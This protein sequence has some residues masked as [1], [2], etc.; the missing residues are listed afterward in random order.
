MTISNKTIKLLVYYFALKKGEKNIKKYLKNMLT[1]KIKDGTI[2]N[3]PHRKDEER[4]STLKSK[5]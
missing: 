2:K 1:N 4:K 5:Q 3:V